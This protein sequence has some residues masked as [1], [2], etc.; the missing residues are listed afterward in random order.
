MCLRYSSSVVAPTQRSSPRASIG[1]SRLAA[2]TAPGAAPAPTIVCSSSRKRIT[3]P[4][5]SLTSLSTPFR[6]SSNSPRYIAPAIRE[7]MSRVI[8]RRSRSESGMSPL[9][10]RCARPSTIAVLPTPGSPINTGLFFVRRLS[11]W[12]TRRIS[13]SRP[14]TG[15]R[16]PCSASSVRSRPKRFSG[17][18]SSSGCCSVGCAGVPLGLI[19][20]S[21]ARLSSRPPGRARV[22]GAHQLRAGPVR[23]WHELR[24][25]A[26]AHLFELF[27]QLHLRAHRRG[28]E[29][30]DARVQTRNLPLE[31]Q[32]ALHARE[33]Q[34]QIGRHLLD[35]LE[36][37][38]VLLR[39]QARALG[40]ALGLDQALGLVHTQRL[41]MHLRQL[42]RDRDHEHPARTRHTHPRHL[43]LGHD[44]AAHRLLPPFADA[45]ESAPAP[46]AAACS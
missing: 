1:L 4:F 18:C 16:L 33:V 43:T 21:R 39:V 14:I 44:A 25:E 11:T 42:G 13:S 31:L 32:H 12:I 9:T 46:P 17:L 34:A 35:V 10:I 37:L 38:D 5:A 30:L 23:V 24:T 26:A 7:P 22:H 45:P 19:A 20:S 2:S 40:R 3:L 6:R 41:R 27:G 28:L 29:L 36:A 8:T 15:S